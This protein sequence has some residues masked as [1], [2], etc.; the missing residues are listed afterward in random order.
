MKGLGKDSIVLLVADGLQRSSL[1][2]WEGYLDVS[3]SGVA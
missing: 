1:E 3:L 2:S